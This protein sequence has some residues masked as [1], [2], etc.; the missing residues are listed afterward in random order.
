MRKACGAGVVQRPRERRALAE[1]QD[2]GA[3]HQHQIGARQ[4]RDERDD[5][6]AVGGLD[7]RAVGEV[8]H[9]AAVR[10]EGEPGP[11]ERRS[12]PARVRDVHLDGGDVEHIAVVIVGVVARPGDAA[13]GVGDQCACLHARASAAPGERAAAASGPRGPPQCHQHRQ[14]HGPQLLRHPL[15]QR[16][17]VRGHHAARLRRAAYARGASDRAPASARRPAAAR[18]SPRASRR[19]T[20]GAMLA[21]WISRMRAAWLW[22]RPGEDSINISSGHV[23]MPQL[24]R[25]QPLVEFRRASRPRRAAARSRGA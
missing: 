16:R 10:D 4:R 7:R 18:C 13:A 8:S 19:A 11:V 2:A 15:Q 25:R 22:V 17:L 3:V 6:R 23:R 9:R 14:H 5:L 24:E 21:R 12:P 20:N 1:T